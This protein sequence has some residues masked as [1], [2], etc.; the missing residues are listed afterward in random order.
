MR[1]ANRNNGDHGT[2]GPLGNPPIN[3]PANQRPGNPQ[4]YWKNRIF[5]G[6]GCA[7]T[8]IIVNGSPCYV[9]YY[10]G[11][12]FGGFVDPGG[13]SMNMNIGGMQ[14]GFDQARGAY[15][16]PGPNFGQGN[17]G[18]VP[19]GNGWINNNGVVSRIDSQTYAP[20]PQDNRD[21]RSATSRVI[22]GSDD[23]Y[24]LNAGLKSKGPLDRDAALAEAV[25]DIAAA[26][27]TGEIAS[28]EKHTPATGMIVLQNKGRTRQNMAVASYLEMTREAVKSMKTVTYTLP[29][30]EPASNGAWLVYGTHVI[31]SEDGSPRA[32]N[33]GFVLKKSGEEVY[34]NRGGRRSGAVT[35]PHKVQDGRPEVYRTPVLRLSRATP[36][37]PV[38]HRSDGL[39]PQPSKTG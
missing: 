30:V 23:E 14:M 4:V 6:P 31:R 13:M 37:D 11:F 17:T 9:P 2:I 20:Q 35:V 3:Y 5:T 38:T 1:C 21:S 12:G 16:N 36:D 27:R 32:F 15:F 18:R 7:P 8:I 19:Y 28:L 33:V 39:T 10:Y 22:R 25:K 26:F 24:Y 34:H 29:N